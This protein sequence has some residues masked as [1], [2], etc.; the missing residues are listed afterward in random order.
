M[1][2]TLVEFAAITVVVAVAEPEA[3]N[4]GFHPHTLIFHD[5]EPHHSLG[6]IQLR[7]I[8][9]HFHRPLCGP[10][11]QFQLNGAIIALIISQAGPRWTDQSGQIVATGLFNPG[12][13]FSHLFSP[14]GR[15]QIPRRRTLSIHGCPHGTVK[16]AM[17]AVVVVFTYPKVDDPG[18][19]P[20]TL[21]LDDIQS[22][23]PLLS[24]DIVVGLIILHHGYSSEFLWI[25]LWLEPSVDIPK[26]NRWD[27]PHSHNSV[28]TG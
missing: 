13:S 23:H 16:R 3:N 9:G 25:L 28:G 22:G 24:S 14:T 10:V 4:A 17:E 2:H 19:H 27:I 20:H 12:I 15:P 1:P 5:L 21:F 6:A 7:C 26:Q 8:P 18:L 11:S